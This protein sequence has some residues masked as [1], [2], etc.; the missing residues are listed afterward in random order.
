[1]LSRVTTLKGLFLLKPLW[2]DVNFS[3]DCHLA[4]MLT[5]MQSKTP[6]QYDSDEMWPNLCID[7]I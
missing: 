3:Q 4:C 2:N 1:V 7:E 5:K 6:D